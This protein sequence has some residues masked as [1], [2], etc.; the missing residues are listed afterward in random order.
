M[1]ICDK[2]HPPLEYAG[3][4][5]APHCLLRPGGKKT[6]RAFYLCLTVIFT[7]WCFTVV[8]A[9]AVMILAP[10]R[11]GG[12]VF[13]LLMGT[14]LIAFSLAVKRLPRLAVSCKRLE[15]TEYAVL[16]QLLVIS[17]FSFVLPRFVPVVAAESKRV[18]GV[19]SLAFILLLALVGLL[20]NHMKNMEHE[21]RAYRMQ[22]QLQQEHGEQARR[23]YDTAVTLQH[24]YTKLYHSLEP[25]IRELDTASP[26]RRYF[27]AYITPI[28]KGQVEN[29]KQLHRIH[30][31]SL[32]NLLDFTAGQASKQEHFELVLAID[33]DI[34]LPESMEMD[35]F[36]I[37]NILIDNALAALAAQSEGLLRVS[38]DGNAETVT[39]QVVNTIVAGT[40]IE[41]FYT[42]QRGNGHGHG[43]KLVREII[44]RNPAIE[45]FTY[46][47]VGYRER[48][49]VVQRV[50]IAL[51]EG[52]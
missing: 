47:G 52:E 50:Q 18:W 44:Y 41:D 34:R 21:R 45:H 32:R 39:L 23:Q 14:A 42:V 26:V 9:S 4:R 2:Q 16:I 33:G 38:A 10:D 7:L 31:D 22:A 29:R 11:H 17:F 49:T 1:R 40:N 24:Y 46:K 48:E 12:T 19:F 37:L 51:G 6:R 43:L 3:K 15:H 25:L 8:T 28:H 13:N 36:R 35:V 30:N 27:E 5:I 20:L